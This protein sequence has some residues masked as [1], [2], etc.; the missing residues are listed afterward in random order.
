M[1]NAREIESFE[2]IADPEEGGD[3]KNHPE[4]VPKLIVKYSTT[5]NVE[6]NFGD[7]S[8]PHFPKSCR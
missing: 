5:A 3:G 4:R 2:N 1:E 6:D 7:T 8:C